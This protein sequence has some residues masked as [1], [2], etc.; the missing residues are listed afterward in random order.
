MRFMWPMGMSKEDWPQSVT[1]FF[2]CRKY[3]F[4]LIALPR[5]PALGVQA[6]VGFWDPAGFTADGDAKVRDM[7]IT[8]FFWRVQSIVHKKVWRAAHN[9]LD[10]NFASLLDVCLDVCLSFHMEA[11]FKTPI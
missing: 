11:C 3:F 4:R 8:F 9:G 7:R 2:E 5:K 10:I 1:L 6:P